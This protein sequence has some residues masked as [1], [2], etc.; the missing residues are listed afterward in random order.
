MR[1]EARRGSFVDGFQT[2]QYAGRAAVE[3]LRE[4]GEDRRMVVI[5]AMDPANPYG[6]SLPSPADGFARV[7]GAYLVLEGGAPVMRIEAGGRRLVPV[8]GLA[9]DRLAAAVST[10]PQLLRA[11][12]PYRG[13]RLEVLTYGDDPAAKSAA[14]EALSR[15][16]FEPSGEGL[17][18]WPSRASRVEG[19]G[20]G[21]EPQLDERR[22]LP[23]RPGPP[24]V[25]NTYPRT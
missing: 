11:P 24:A 23:R 13:R 18:L 3:R 25:L 19:H 6:A 21:S 12:A 2:M 8:N 22:A 5:A 14:A 9:G 17:V 1:G 10:L 20:S 4:T 16:G 15:A 7:P